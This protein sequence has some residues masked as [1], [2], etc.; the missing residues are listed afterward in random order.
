MSH[1][2]PPFDD[3]ERSRDPEY[4]AEL[5]QRVRRMRALRG[6]SRKTLARVSGISERYLAQL[7]SGAGN[8]SIMLLR[9]VAGATGA[10]LEDLVSEAGQPAEWPLIREML[11]H[12]S[13]SAIEAAKRALGGDQ[14]AAPAPAGNH[15][16]DRVALIGLRGAGKSTVGRL[17]ARKLGWSFIELNHEV[18]RA[19]GL[20]VTEVFKLYG[21]DGYRRLEQKALRSVIERPGPVMLAT[22]GGI[23][24]DPLT[25]DTLL[26][27]FFTVWVTARPE[28]H[29]NRVRGQGDLRPMANDRAAM[30]ELVAILTSREPLYARAGAT[31]DT[32]DRSIEE[33]A[34]ALVKLVGPSPQSTGLHQA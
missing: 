10:P 31:L 13:P 9:R 6:M 14:N 18:E 23:V 27:S 28:Q 29:M 34:A 33:S 11:R 16:I 4:L 7:E 20:S 32:A 3:L 1:D 24:A 26:S 25:F 17:A 2:K 30:E 22:G 19:A 5:G 15:A 8:L 12:A 21:Q